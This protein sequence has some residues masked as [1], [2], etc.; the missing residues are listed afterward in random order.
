MPIQSIDTNPMG[1]QGGLLFDLIR[2]AG[3]FAGKNQLQPVAGSSEDGGMP[4]YKT[5]FWDNMY[6]KQGERLN[7]ARAISDQNYADQLAQSGKLQNQYNQIENANILPRAMAES[8]I[9][10]A[11]AGNRRMANDMTKAGDMGELPQMD[12]RAKLKNLSTAIL[13]DEAAGDAARLDSLQTG[14]KILGTQQSGNAL[15][16]ATGAELKAAA[17]LAAR[18]SALAA[19]VNT[20][21]NIATESSTYNAGINREN[22]QTQSQLNQAR[23]LLAGQNNDWYKYTTATPSIQARADMNEAATGR[24]HVNLPPGSSVFFPGSGTSMSADF[25]GR[26]ISTGQ[27]V[28]PESDLRDLRA[29]DKALREKINNPV[30]QEEILRKAASADAIRSMNPIGQSTAIPVQKQP[31]FNNP[32][33]IRTGF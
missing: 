26:G 23:A 20:P 10:I 27:P 18:K 3:Q 6:G 16:D 4:M 28:V 9:P 31:G 11:T 17:Q 32:R 7:T 29:M 19:N 12:Y 22:A 5:G 33:N 1:P 21:S 15:A 24:N 8:E 13:K 2:A 25:Y 14:Q 30:N